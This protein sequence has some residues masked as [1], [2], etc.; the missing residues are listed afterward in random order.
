LAGS[1]SK[2]LITASI[3]WSKAATCCSRDSTCSSGVRHAGPT[4]REQVRT[5]GT[6]TAELLM[7]GNWLAAEGR[8]AFR[9][10]G[11]PGRPPKLSQ[12]PTMPGVPRTTAARRNQMSDCNPAGD[13]L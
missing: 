11:A 12:P 6:T 3:R 1:F 9:R 4:P 8:Q 7:L 2:G 5:F 13:D 10:R